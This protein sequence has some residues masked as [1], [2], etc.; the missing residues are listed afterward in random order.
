[1]RVSQVSTAFPRH[2]LD[3]LDHS[4]FDELARLAKE[5]HDS[6]NKRAEPFTQADLKLWIVRAWKDASQLKLDHPPTLDILDIGTGPADFVYVCQR[7]GHRCVGLDQPGD[8]PFWECLHQWLG[9][10]RVRARSVQPKERLPADLG[11]FDLVTAFR[12]QFNYNANEKR[13]WTLDEW[14]YFLDDLRDNVLN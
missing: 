3:G 14:T 7:R 2:L 10:R 8:F 12:A 4:S 1:M 9:L 5:Q 11:R 6:R 13:L